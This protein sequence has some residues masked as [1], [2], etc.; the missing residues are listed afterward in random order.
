MVADYSNG[1]LSVS[2]Y[3]SRSVKV[4]RVSFGM[5]MI[6]TEGS[7]RHHRALYTLRRVASS[8]VVNVVLTSHHEYEDFIHWMKGYGRL[9]TD[10]EATGG[11]VM[12]VIV[13]SRGFDLAGVPAGAPIPFGEEVA[14]FVWRIGLNFVGTHSPSSAVPA[15]SRMAPLPEEAV[16]YF[17]PGGTQLA[18]T[19]QGTDYMYHY[20]ETVGAIESAINPGP[21]RP[22]QG[23]Y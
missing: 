5:E 12:R 21:I 4:E 10:G 1:K 11:R 18:G 2:G 20:E 13:P 15:T 8:F 6:A 7:A 17:Y 19:E 16:P 9:L 3:G 22:T 23:A 14:E